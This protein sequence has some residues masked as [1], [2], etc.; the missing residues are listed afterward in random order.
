MDNNVV[1]IKSGFQEISLDK[2]RAG[3]LKNGKFLYE[4]KH[5]SKVKKNNTIIIAL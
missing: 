1:V 2:F 3:T 4:S 5:V